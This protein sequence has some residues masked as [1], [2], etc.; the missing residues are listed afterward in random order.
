MNTITKDYGPKGK[1][2]LALTSH[3]YRFS[4]ATHLGE[5]G[6]DIRYIQEFLRHE[7]LDTTVRYIQQGFRQL[8]DIHRRTH[9]S[10]GG[11]GGAS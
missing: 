8:Q 11:G 4:I 3:V 2:E 10:G 9:P 5:N 6:V 7:S 1:I